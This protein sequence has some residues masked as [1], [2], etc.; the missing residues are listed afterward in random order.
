MFSQP[1]RATQTLELPRAAL[2]KSH[3]STITSRSQP[4]SIERRGIDAALRGGAARSLAVHQSR[5]GAG[6]TRKRERKRPHG[7]TMQGGADGQTK[8]CF[9]RVGLIRLAALFA[10]YSPC[11]IS[12]K[13]LCRP[14]RNQA[15]IMR[16]RISE[17]V[18]A[19][20]FTGRCVGCLAPRRLTGAIRLYYFCERINNQL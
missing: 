7:Y 11:S 20:N 16:K 6:A 4:A 1:I 12:S 3:L 8:H 14:G 15:L 2:R 9:A 5:S 13:A 17:L 10:R 18:S 19:Y